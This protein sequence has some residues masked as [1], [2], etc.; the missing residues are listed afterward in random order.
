M[1]VHLLAPD[2]EFDGGATTGPFD[3]ALIRDLELEST[4]SVMGGGDD[5]VQ[6]V[7]RSVLLADPPPPATVR[8][9]QAIFAD[10]LARAPA[11]AEL[12]A[13]A[14]GAL[15]DE[16]EVWGFGESPESVLYRGT[17]LLALL[18]PR[19]RRLRE[20]AVTQGAAFRSEGFQ[21]LFS[22]VATDL[23]ETYFRSVEDLLRQLR[24]PRGTLLAL[25]LGAGNRGSEYSLRRPPEERRRWLRL[26][27]VGRRSPFSFEL[28]E[29]D[30]A[31]RRALSELRDH[32]VASSAQA[33]R[34]STA[35]LHAF[36]TQLR[37]ELDFYLGGANLHAR[38]V[39]AGLPVCVPEPLDPSPFGLSAQGLYDLSLALGGRTTV[40]P[41]DLDVASRP[42]VV[43]TG[44]NQGGKSTFL[45]SVGLAVLLAQAGLS[46]PARR[47]STSVPRGVFT[48]FR[49]EEDATMTSGKFEEE[50]DRMRAIAGH[51]RPGSLLL[52]NESFASTNE[53]EGSEIAETVL[54][55]FLDG[56]VRVVLVTH[57]FDL[58]D[59]LR[60][61]EPE[62]ALFLRAE[63]SPEGHRTFRIVPGE[64]L[65]T[66]FGFDL[67]R[68]VFGPAESGASL[69]A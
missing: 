55:A 28:G 31:G 34:Q 25:R 33:L 5:H 10:C 14:L 44:A 50:L 53:R 16:R 60:R 1:R 67:Y 24:F 42:L 45:R 12:R 39:G 46:V 17:K 35:R 52:A 13:L 22:G 66:G 19:L 6:T 69:T 23:D 54:R 59:R 62:R 37:D 29:R 11:V 18:L 43:I 56:G 63:R 36:F 57:F 41:N 40:V 30:E 64:P 15:G 58:A 21:R 65:P 38:L 7:A 26:P 32:G 47:F 4:L 27:F 9:R 2:R 68:Q 8:Y 61:I 51:L 20:L 48:H 3:A 49:R